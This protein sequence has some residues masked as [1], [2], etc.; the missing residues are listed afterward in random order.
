MMAA[1]RDRFR[2]TLVDP[3]VCVPTARAKIKNLNFAKHV[4]HVAYSAVLQ[5]FVKI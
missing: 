1:E 2:R 4:E 5:Y 3:R